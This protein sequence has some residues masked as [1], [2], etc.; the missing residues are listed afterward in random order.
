[1][2][3]DVIIKQICVEKLSKKK[4]A[5]SRFAQSRKY[6]Y[7]SLLEVTVREARGWLVADGRSWLV[8]DTLR[9]PGRLSR[10]RGTLAG[11]CP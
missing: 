3:T 8:V 10:G 1:M 7:L 2:N 11:D 6:T 4:N 9:S 5:T